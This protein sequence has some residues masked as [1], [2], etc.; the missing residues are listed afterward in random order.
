MDAQ[1]TCTLQA[2]TQGLL[3]DYQMSSYPDGIP[4]LQYVDDT[5]LFIEGLVEEARNLSTLLD[6][7]MNFLGL[8]INS[9]KSAFQGFG[10]TQEEELQCLEALGVYPCG[11]WA[12]H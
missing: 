7:F 4:L 11:S 2:C 12:Y 6:I 1:A 9:T 5:I 10:L 3:K 8:Q